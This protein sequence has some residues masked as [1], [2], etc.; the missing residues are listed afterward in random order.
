MSS[1]NLPRL[2]KVIT[3]IALALALAYLLLPSL[4]IDHITLILL[5]F[6]LIPWLTPLVKS[7]EAP[8]GWKIEL[9]DEVKRELELV[10]SGTLHRLAALDA[11]LVGYW[12]KN[13][14][15]QAEES[16]E[17]LAVIDETASQLEREF[18]NA[19]QLEKL[20]IGLALRTV[21]WEYLNRA[22]EHYS[23]ST[24]YQEIKTRVLKG[25]KTIEQSNAPSSS[26]KA[27]A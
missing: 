24:P 17:R 18:A 6:A 19:G 22:R 12:E 9:R 15:L 27:D 4:T 21:Y 25:L 23:S 8:G 26:P 7:L 13:K 11:R 2:R 16:A 1:P 3:L 20:G 14:F 10:A 5:A